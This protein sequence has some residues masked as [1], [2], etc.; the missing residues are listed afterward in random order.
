MHVAEI[1]IC[2]TP[3]LWLGIIIRHECETTEAFHSKEK[4]QHVLARHQ[5]HF[6]IERAHL[7]TTCHVLWT[8][9]NH[10]SAFRW[11]FPYLWLCIFRVSF[12]KN[13]SESS[14]LFFVLFFFC[15]CSVRALFSLLLEICSYNTQGTVNK[16]CLKKT[17]FYFIPP[18]TVDW[19]VW[20]IL[21]EQGWS[22]RTFP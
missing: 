6:V 17:H 3:P 1:L 4:A 10:Y 5:F 13:T 15:P 16:H 19:C 18:P 11:F 9:S 21:S 8:V 2:I 22:W 20:L 12:S 7:T 14:K